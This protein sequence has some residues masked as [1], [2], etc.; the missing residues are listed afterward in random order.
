[1]KFLINRRITISMIFLAITMLGIISYRQLSM[2]LL[3]NAEYPT[4]SVNVNSRTE[5]DPSYMESEV[6]M[7]IEGAI[8]TVEGIQYL[9]SDIGSSS[10][11]LTVNFKESVN[12]KYASIQVQEKIKE[13][14]KTLP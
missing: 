2:E 3:P 5:V 10:A 1:M 11:R 4:I 9:N 13:I 12:L 8:K 6:V 14:S 7:A